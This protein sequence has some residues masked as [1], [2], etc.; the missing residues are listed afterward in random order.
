MLI[1]LLSDSFYWSAPSEYKVKKKGVKALTVI[2]FKLS[3]NNNLYH[4]ITGGGVHV[5]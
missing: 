4:E 1:R 2:I 3:L 5:V